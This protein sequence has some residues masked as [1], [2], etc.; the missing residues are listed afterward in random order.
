MAKANT[1]KLTEQEKV[2]LKEIAE[3]ESAIRSGFD[4]ADDELVTNIATAL[5]KQKAE[6]TASADK[7]QAFRETAEL[8]VSRFGALWSIAS[9][10]AVKKGCKDL[11][12]GFAKIAGEVDLTVNQVKELHQVYMALATEKVG[13]NRQVWQNIQ[14]WSRHATG[15]KAKHPDVKE[16]QAKEKAEAEANETPTESIAKVIKV[17]T[18]QYQYLAKIEEAN[19]SVDSLMFEIGKILES[20]GVEMLDV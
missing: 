19:D 2:Q 18:S 6:E 5:V 12:A 17:L 16:A 7:S 20:N 9:V 3:K 1:T 15:S 8:L 14:Y 11:A 4:I 13:G 10:A